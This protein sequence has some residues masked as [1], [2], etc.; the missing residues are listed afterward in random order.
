MVNV[1]VSEAQDRQSKRTA[2][3]A[4]A[5]IAVLS[6]AFIGLVTFLDGMAG[7]VQ[8]DQVPLA[9]E[10][11]TDP[12]YTLLIGSDSRKGTALYTGNKK[13][14]AQVDQHSD[15]MTLVRVDPATYTITLVTVPR[16]TVPAGS[17]AKINDALL[18]GDPTKV[19]AAVEDLTGVTVDYYMMTTFT[20]FETLVNAMGGV[21]VDVPKD[22]TV[23]DPMT[24]EDVSLKAGKEQ[25]LDGSEALVLAR[26]RKEYGTDQ[27]ALRQVNVR[28]IEIA[29]IDKAL[30][31]DSE[32]KANALLVDL[33]KNTTTNLDMAVAGYLMVDF[34]THREAVTI[35]S[36]TGPYDGGENASGAWVVEEDSESWA[37]L[38]AV[39]DAVGDPSGIVPLPS[40]S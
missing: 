8:E 15:V 1:N 11:S 29:L 27:D 19:V 35:Y 4:V 7:H 13:D 32:K 26:A 37:V 40:F 22:V 2:A 5:V 30:A 9:S 21:T 18:D 6:L 14:H 10:S 36:C 16:D 31:L 17:S 24:A 39:V 23:P 12:F 34:V 38:M 25:T 33:E 3:V 20:S 28:N